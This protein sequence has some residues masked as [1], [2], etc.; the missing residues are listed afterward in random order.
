MNSG[1]QYFVK[2][3]AEERI[4]AERAVDP[5]ARQSHLD[6]AEEYARARELRALRADIA[7]R[8]SNGTPLLKIVG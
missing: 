5:R 2:R 6:M 1:D 3:E 8:V 4:A 7:E